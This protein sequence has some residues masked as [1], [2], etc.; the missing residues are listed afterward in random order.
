MFEG[1]EKPDTERDDQ[2]EDQSAPVDVGKTG[3]F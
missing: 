2:S 1:D 3:D